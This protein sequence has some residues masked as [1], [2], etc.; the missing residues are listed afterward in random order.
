MLLRFR[1]LWAV[2]V[3]VALLLRT[4]GNQLAY[5]LHHSRTVLHAISDIV[6]LERIHKLNIAKPRCISYS[7]ERIP[8]RRTAVLD[9]GRHFRFVLVQMVF[10]HERLRN[11]ER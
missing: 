9:S 2:P 11:L 1:L 7:R 8:S 3:Y 4:N 6:V 10:D 5:V